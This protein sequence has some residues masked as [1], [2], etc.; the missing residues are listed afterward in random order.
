LT[1]PNSPA[2]RNHFGTT[3]HQHGEAYYP[4]ALAVWISHIATGI[5]AGEY[6]GTSREGDE[7]VAPPM[8]KELLKPGDL[9]LGDAHI[10]TFATMSVGISR[11]AHFVCRAQ[12][13]FKVDAHIT[14]RHAAGDADAQLRRSEYMKKKYAHLHLPE[15]LQL[16]VVSADIPA[17]DFLNGTERADFFYESSALRIF[18]IRRGMSDSSA[19]D[20]RNPEQRCQNAPGPGRDSKPAPRICA[21][22]SSRSFMSP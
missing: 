21:P 9:F 2:N 8:L 10:G 18:N 12:G 6:L 14:R 5:V 13:A 3:R 15:Q 1:L 16:R 17:R 11:G 19:L 7:S 22:R 4:Q 20:S